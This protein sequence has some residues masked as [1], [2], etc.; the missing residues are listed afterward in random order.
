MARR[1]VKPGFILAA[2]MALQNIADLRRLAGDI[3]DPDTEMTFG[4][5]GSHPKTGRGALG[6]I[7]CPILALDLQRQR[8]TVTQPDQETGQ[9]TPPR[10]M[11]SCLVWNNASAGTVM[12]PLTG[13]ARASHASFKPG[14]SSD[15]VA[16]GQIGH[17]VAGQ[18]FQIFLQVVEIGF[19]WSQ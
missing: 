6:A 4:V 17:Q 18:V 2:G 19:W 16:E 15:F 7:L 14:R 9:V 3:P 11:A 13:V 5:D 12:A 8:P 10:A 1:F